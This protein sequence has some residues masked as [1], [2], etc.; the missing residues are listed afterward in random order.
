MTHVLGIELRRSA[1][2]GTAAVLLVIGVVALFFANGVEF[3]AG[4]MQ[5][6]M[7]QRL[8][9]VLL[10]PLALAA[11]AWQASR[12]SR[13]KVEELFATT[14]R[15]RA[16]RTVP[17]LGAMALAVV[18]GYLAMG[19]VGGL[20]IIGTARYFPMTVLVVTAVGVL[21]LIG[22]VWLGQAIGRLLPWLVTAP[23]LGV[24]GAG[25]R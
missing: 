9:L 8:Y 13:S 2:L 17:T 22:A 6:A 18:C 20:W 10:W 4:W 11:G 1:A 5:L 15:P 24:D 25:L 12:E 16:Q 23:A 19:I 21:A 7:S 3:E 14:P